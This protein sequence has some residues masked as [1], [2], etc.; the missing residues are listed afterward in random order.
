MFIG[1]ELSTVWRSSV[2][3]KR[4]GEKTWSLVTTISIFHPFG[5][6]E[7]VH[8]LGDN[9]GSILFHSAWGIVLLEKLTVFS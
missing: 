2:T 6:L 7:A 8:I 5:E 1:I 9:D 3:A 4:R